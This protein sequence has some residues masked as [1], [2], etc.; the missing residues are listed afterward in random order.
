MQ[1]VENCICIL[2]NL[3]YRLDAEVPNKYTQLNHM[4]RSVYMDKTLTGCFNSRSGKMENDEYGVP[5]PEEDFKPKGPSWLYHSDAIRTY[6]S[7]MDQSKKDATLEACAGALQNLTA[8]R[9]L[10][11]TSLSSTCIYPNVSALPWNQRVSKVGKTSK[12]TD[13]HHFSAMKKEN[14]LL[15]SQG[16]TSS[17]SIVFDPVGY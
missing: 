2:H 6:L 15:K 3:S 8:S 7:L 5:L 4:A 12:V 9:G 11:R 10:V 14:V 13:R 16:T 1:S 17:L